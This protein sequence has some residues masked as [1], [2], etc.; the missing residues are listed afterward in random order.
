MGSANFQHVML[1]ILHKIRK[2]G[3]IEKSD[4]AANIYIL[5]YIYETNNTNLGNLYAF[6]SLVLCLVN[7]GQNLI[8]LHNILQLGSELHFYYLICRQMQLGK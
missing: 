6:C 8:L 7:Y 5:G 4:M 2:N 1:Q 3:K